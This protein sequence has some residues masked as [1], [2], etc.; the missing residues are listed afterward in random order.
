M[1]QATFRNPPPTFRAAPFW[2]WN[3]DLDPEELVR[4]VGLMDEAGWGGFFMHSRVG[5]APD[6]LAAYRASGYYERIVQERA[7]AEVGKGAGYPGA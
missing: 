3:D 6:P 7:G 5:L 4:Q 2:S 1:D